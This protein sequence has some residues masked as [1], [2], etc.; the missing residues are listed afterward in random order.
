MKG[1]DEIQAMIRELKAVRPHVPQ[2]SIMGDDNWAAI[3]AQITVLSE[4]L[5]Y[6]QAETRYGDVEALDV[7]SAALDAADWLTGDFTGDLADGWPTDG[8]FEYEEAEDYEITTP[9]SELTDEQVQAA[10]REV[11]EI[12]NRD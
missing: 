10:E 11:D 4:G 8:E 2:R 5:T 1:K 12:L 3:D 9:R 7:F 6:N